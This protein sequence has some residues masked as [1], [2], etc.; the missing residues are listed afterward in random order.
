MEAGID[1]INPAG[2]KV[3][4]PAGKKNDYLSRKGWKEFIPGLIR[5]KEGQEIVFVHRP[6]GGL[7]DIISILPSLLELRKKF[8]RVIFALPETYHFLFNNLDIEAVSFQEWHNR[9]IDYNENVAIDLWCPAGRHEALYNFRPVKNRIQNFADACEVDYKKPVLEKNEKFIKEFRSQFDTRKKFIGIQLESANLSKDWPYF[10]ELCKI[11]VKKYNVFVFDRCNVLNV[12]GVK[13][14]IRNTT[15]MAVKKVSAMDLIIAPDSG[16]MWVGLAMNIKTVALFG[17]T[18]G[19]LTLKYFDDHN[20]R[21]LEGGLKCQ[22]CYYANYRCSN[23]K[24][25]CMYEIK[26]NDVLE[27]IDE[28]EI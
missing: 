9:K 19:K 3:R 16:F 11:L 14:I 27:A 25:D 4:I 1:L 18:N 21:L 10:N 12:T 17:P 8:K 20:Y 26:V 22:P 24:G 15:E 23:K 7:G 6:S 28:L 2:R 5:K 13:S